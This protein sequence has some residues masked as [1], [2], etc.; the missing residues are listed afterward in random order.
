MRKR[1]ARLDRTGPRQ[2]PLSASAGA[3]PVACHADLRWRR[4]AASRAA[5]GNGG[6]HRAGGLGSAVGRLAHRRAGRGLVAALD[7]T[8]HPLAV[9]VPQ[10]LAAGRD[11]V[12]KL[13]AAPPDE[14]PRV[15]TRGWGKD[16]R[17]GGANQ[18]DFRAED[19]LRAPGERSIYFSDPDSNK[20]QITALGKENWSLISDEEK[21][22][23]TA[24]NREKLGRGLSRFDRGSKPNP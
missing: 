15:S 14:R 17:C 13:A 12:G 18:G 6:L 22:K 2:T 9:L 3:D 23:R 7:R 16:E 5:A 1:G 8:G 24:E 4:A 10:L 20:L 19:G 21:W 11:V